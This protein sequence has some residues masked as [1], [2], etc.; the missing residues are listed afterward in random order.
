VLHSQGIKDAVPVFVRPAS[1]ANADLVR[2]FHGEPQTEGSGK[3]ST[4]SGA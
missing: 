3:G 1:R 4:G 2:E